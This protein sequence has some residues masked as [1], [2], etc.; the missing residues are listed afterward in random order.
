[1]F[2]VYGDPKSSRSPVFSARTASGHSQPQ[3]IRTETSS[4]H[5]EIQLISSMWQRPS[6]TS[7]YSPST[8]I[9]SVSFVCRECHRW[10]ETE[11]DVKSTDQPCIWALNDDQVFDGFSKD[12]RLDAHDHGMTA[13]ATGLFSI[14][15][16]PRSMSD[17]Q[18]DDETGSDD[19]PQKDSGGN[20][21]FVNQTDAWIARSTL[22]T[23][24]GLALG[25]TFLVLYPAGIIAIRTRRGN[26]FKYHWILQLL[27]TVTLTVGVMIGVYLHRRIDYTHQRVG[28]AV[29][30]LA[31]VQTFLGWKHHL[32]FIKTQRKNW[33]STAHVLLG[34]LL[35]VAG[36]TNVILGMSIRGRSQTF[37]ELLFVF[38]VLETVSIGYYV[39]SA[40]KP[41]IDDHAKD[42]FER[43][44]EEEERF[45]VG[46]EDESS[47]DGSALDGA[48]DEQSIR[49]KV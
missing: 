29:L 9:A 39:A 34:R 37:I 44:R 48:R 15:M 41:A 14:D 17:E 10:L 35:P 40:Q 31:W 36:A 26:A 21:Y 11:V 20:S 30:I 38:I 32:Y 27:A 46:D 22:W 28:V 8:Y 3:S 23:L 16:R 33:T 19:R 45:T 7:S 6:R 1:M 5:P 18:L 49:E 47:I 43:L 25:L 2:I 4:P 13:G 12:E 42:G 24:H